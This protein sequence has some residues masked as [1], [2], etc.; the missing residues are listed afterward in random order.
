MLSPSPLSP[1]QLFQ[2]V[3]FSTGELCRLGSTRQTRFNNCT[4]DGVSLLANVFYACLIDNICYFS[5]IVAIPC[6]VGSRL[7]LNMRETFYEK[8]IVLA[9][10]PS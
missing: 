9:D 8:T 5:W 3:F 6:V 2:D 4:C 7:L 1:H 10:A